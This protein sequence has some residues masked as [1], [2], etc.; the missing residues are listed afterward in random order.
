MNKRRKILSPGV[1]FDKFPLKNRVRVQKTI[2]KKRCQSFIV[3]VFMTYYSI[4]VSYHVDMKHYINNS[5][6]YD[7]LHYV[8]LDKLRTI[9][10]LMMKLMIM[11]AVVMIHDK[12]DNGTNISDNYHNF[13]SCYHHYQ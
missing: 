4:V 3:N 2:F 10:V 5:D 1:D 13:H 8:I 7:N 12:D 9:T 6:V 11:I